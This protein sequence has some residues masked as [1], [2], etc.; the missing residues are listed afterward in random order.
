MSGQLTS[1]NGGSSLQ[2]YQE[3]SYSIGDASNA[4]GYKLPPKYWKIRINLTIHGI[5]NKTLETKI[6]KY[7][8]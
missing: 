5:Y 7:T 8:F 2:K 4:N 3:F 6:Y 1:K